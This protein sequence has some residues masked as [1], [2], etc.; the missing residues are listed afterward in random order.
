MTTTPHSPASRRALLGA[1]AAGTALAAVGLPAPRAAAATGPTPAPA[2]PA[3]VPLPPLDPAALH[4]AIGDLE[5]P[6]ATAAQLQVSGSAG[7]WYGTSGVADLRSGRSVRAGDKVRIGSITKM[8]VATVALQLV[9]ERRLCLDTPVRRC[10]PGLL[11]ARF[12]TVTLA[13]LLGHG[14][15]L[16][17]E[18][19][20]PH[21]STPEKVFAHRFD[22]WTPEQIVAMVT[23]GDRELKFAPGSKQE[24]RGIN[25]VLAALVVERL[26]GR[27]YGEEIAR[28]ILRPLGLRD[29]SVPGDERRIHGPHVHGYLRMSDGGLRDITEINPSGSWGEGE[30]ISTTDDLT[31]F[32][33]ALFSGAL[34]PPHVLRVMFTMPPD[35][36]RMVDGGPAR[37]STGLQTVTVNGVTFWGKTGEQYGYA[38][39]A[40]AT[41]DQRRCMVLSF[42]PTQ[43]DR[44]QE[45]MSLRVA[46]AVTGGA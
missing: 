9:A 1:A 45:Q 37:F 14:S 17:D 6:P 34:L 3:P 22:P 20:V 11:P 29:T 4:A 30:M 38:S 18:Q 40:F 46:N 41:R 21:L 2:A 16:P 5:H 23:V 31:R 7:R 15:G 36:V 10:L 28:R 24:Y 19:G 25:Y 39:F 44:S 35:D 27:P 12:G 26:T 13:H 33:H 8:F 43:R 42:N 32:T